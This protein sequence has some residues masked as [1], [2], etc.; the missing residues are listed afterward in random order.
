MTEIEL[1]AHVDEPDRVERAIASFASFAGETVKRDTYYRLPREGALPEGTLPDGTFL[2]AV[3][4]AVSFLSAIGAAACVIFGASKSTVIAICLFATAF[5]AAAS[6]I[7]LR[8]GKTGASAD[9]HAS[10]NAGAGRG[11]PIKVRIREEAGRVT[12]TYKRKEVRESVE[13]NDEREFTIDDR[14]AF[15]AFVG[16]VG[17]EPDSVKEKRTKGWVCKTAG[18]FDATIELSLVGP[19][20]WFVEIEILLERPDAAATDRATGELRKLLAKCGVG[21][22]EIETRYYTEMLAALEPPFSQGPKK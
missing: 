13:V 20:G 18:G 5:V 3:A 6:L 7:G 8:R 17:F 12:V 9:A 2:A 21:E 15:E 19:L 11:N 16:D 22:R 10:A 14:A 4:S 1:K